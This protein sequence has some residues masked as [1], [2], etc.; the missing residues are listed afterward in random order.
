MKN[1]EK[2]LSKIKRYLTTKDL[3]ELGVM[4][5]DQARLMQQVL[6]YW[7]DKENRKLYRKNAGRGN[8]QLVVGISERMQLLKACHNKMGH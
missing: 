8:P 7:L 4:T 3:S 5:T 2:M 1:Q 6:H